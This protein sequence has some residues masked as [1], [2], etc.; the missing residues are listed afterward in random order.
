MFITNLPKSVLGKQIFKYF[1]FCLINF[2]IQVNCSMFDVEEGLCSLQEGPCSL[3]EELKMS[4]DFPITDNHNHPDDKEVHPLNQILPENNINC[5]V[6]DQQQSIENNALPQDSKEDSKNAI[7]QDSKEDSKNAL[8]QDSKNAFQQDNKN[9]IPQDS[10]NFIP[11][12]SKEDGKNAIPQAIKK[13]STTKSTK[14][15]HQSRRS[16]K[17]SH[18]GHCVNGETSSTSCN[19]SSMGTSSTDTTESQFTQIFRYNTI[20][21]ALSKSLKYISNDYV[22]ISKIGKFI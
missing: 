11:Q 16:K 3:Q 19:V 22:V 10:K 18:G 8:P 6:L 1:L 21:L 14:P 2:I 20:K 12:D 13:I 17:E 5:E 15:N 9:A 7:Q 4:G